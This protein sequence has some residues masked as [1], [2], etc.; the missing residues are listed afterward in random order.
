MKIVHQVR[1]PTHQAVQV[2]CEFDERELHIERPF[3][4][5]YDVGE[6]ARHYLLALVGADRCERGRTMENVR[7]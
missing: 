3:G 5:M 1:I 2:V 6:S 4:L 7:R